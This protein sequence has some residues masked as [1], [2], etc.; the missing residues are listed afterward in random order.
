M[1]FLIRSEKIKTSSPR[2]SLSDMPDARGVSTEKSDGVSTPGMESEGRFLRSPFFC[3]ATEGKNNEIKKSLFLY[4]VLF[5]T[6]KTI[7]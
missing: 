4:F 7:F 1:Q 2:I 5:I 6:L 3:V